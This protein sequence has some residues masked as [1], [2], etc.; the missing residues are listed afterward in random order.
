MFIYFVLVVF[1]YGI[2]F[3]KYFIMIKLVVFLSSY[4]NIYI[5]CCILLNNTTTYNFPY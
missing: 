4:Q 3:S 1:F 5:N 2:S